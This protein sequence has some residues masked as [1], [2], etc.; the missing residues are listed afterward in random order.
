MMQER[1]FRIARAIYKSLSPEMVPNLTS[2][3]LAL[4]V[5]YVSDEMTVGEFDHLASL[6]LEEAAL[7]LDTLAG[8]A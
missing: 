3:D 2:P 4:L 5:R 7:R 1:E 6:L 8:A